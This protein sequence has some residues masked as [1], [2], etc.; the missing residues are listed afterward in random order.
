MFGG[1]SLTVGGFKAK[2]VFGWQTDFPVCGFLLCF[3]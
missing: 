1:V 3:G 2:L